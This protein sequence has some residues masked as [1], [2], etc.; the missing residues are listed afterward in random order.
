MLVTFRSLHLGGSTHRFT[1][2]VLRTRE[3]V[4]TPY[5]FAIFTLDSHLSP[6]RS[7]GAHHVAF[8][9]FI[10]YIYPLYCCYSLF[11]APFVNIFRLLV[12][13]FVATFYLFIS[14]CRLCFLVWYSSHLIFFL[15]VV[16]WV[17]TIDQK[18]TRKVS[19]F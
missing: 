1:P 11:V 14:T 5:S 9:F 13:P 18:P 19:F 7:L 12:G 15:Q 3:C 8:P 17:T 6:S 10:R 2:K 4:Q 16:F